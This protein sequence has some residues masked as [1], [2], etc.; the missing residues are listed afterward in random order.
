MKTRLAFKI[1]FLQAVTVSLSLF[2]FTV[3]DFLFDTGG[4][5][6][7]AF[8]VPLV[9]VSGLFT[10]SYVSMLSK[11]M[12]NLASTA[13]HITQGDL[14]TLV[15]FDQPSR[16]PDEVDQVAES[17]NTML[18]NL[19]ELVSHLQK[20]ARNVAENATRLSKAAENVNT[21]AEGVSKSIAVIRRGAELQNEL[22]NKA[23]RLINELS[24]GIE[25]T[26]QAA[27]DAARAA[28]ETHT[29]A[30][31]GT[32]VA[33]LAVDKLQEVFRRVEQASKR[34]FAFGEKSQAIGKIVEVITKISQQTN[35]LALNATIEAARAGEYGRGFAVVADEVRKLAE[36]SGK[37]AEQITVLV[38]D[39][40]KDSESAVIGMRDGTR[41][42][43]ASR[44]DLASIIH[45][46][47]GIVE[48]A[49]RGAEKAEQIARTSQGQLAGS[50][51]MVKAINNIQD[52]AKQ[53]MQ[54]TVEVSRVTAD[55][56]K[57]MEEMA[58]SALE[59]SNL[60]LELEHVVSRFRLGS[61]PP[62]ASS[63]GGAPAGSPTPGNRSTVPPS[64]ERV[65]A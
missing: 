33:N 57:S 8:V 1:A 35:L 41:E 10:W 49:L 20:T 12:Q 65:P 6:V 13:S 47:E 24:A 26:A 44:E 48:S 23:N 7:V 21:S 11:N 45:S 53:N 64:N 29:A 55:Q 52:V 22:V 38:S 18:Q 61:T 54:A 5:R 63:S 25:R 28:A 9:I 30:R 43:N 16:Y 31:T 51:E 62:T 34:V 46:L 2:L 17:I 58:S 60:S 59:M 3:S 42:L 27:Q 39:I 40:A 37:S 36:S 32:E 15:R 14:S 56:S 50:L 4:L 19:R